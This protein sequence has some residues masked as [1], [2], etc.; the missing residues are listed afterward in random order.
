MAEDKICY[1][2]TRLQSMAKQKTKSVTS[3]QGYIL[4][5]GRRQKFLPAYKA[6]FYGIAEDKICYQLTKLH[7]MA[8]QKTKRV[9]DY[10]VGHCRRKI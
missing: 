4:W 6:T 2:L 5:H 8:T 3:L 9:K 1:Q 10:T 7:S